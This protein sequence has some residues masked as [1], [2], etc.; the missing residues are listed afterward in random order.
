M[1]RSQPDKFAFERSV[2]WSM[3]FSKYAL[4]T[5][6]ED[7]SIPENGKLFKFSM[8]IAVVAFVIFSLVKFDFSFV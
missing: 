7:K 3:A 4:G 1:L 8:L 2:R 5:S 6:I